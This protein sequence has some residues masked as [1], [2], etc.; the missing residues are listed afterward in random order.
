MN[1]VQPSQLRG[2]PSISLFRENI[3]EYFNRAD[4][5]PVT[6][7]REG[8]MYILLSYVQY[9]SIVNASVGASSVTG[10]H[11]VVTIT[12]QPGQ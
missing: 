2:T 6:I 1:D 11:T 8:R 12:R 7:S 3:K 9:V 4:R 5:Q 10:V